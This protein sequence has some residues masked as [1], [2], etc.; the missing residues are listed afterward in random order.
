[1]TGKTFPAFPAHAHPQFCVSGKRPMEKIVTHSPRPIYLSYERRMGFLMALIYNNNHC[2]LWDIRPTQPCPLSYMYIYS[3]IYLFRKA[4]TGNANR[5]R[6]TAAV[7]NW[8]NV[9]FFLS[10]L[11]YQVTIG[12]HWIPINHWTTRIRHYFP[13]DLR[14]WVLRYR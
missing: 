2:F 11:F 1:M 8:W 3:F 6:A 14:H 9:D 5:A 13:H 4:G 12:G 10:I 7:F